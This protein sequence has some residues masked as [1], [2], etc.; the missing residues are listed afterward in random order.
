[1]IPWL[2]IAGLSLLLLLAWFWFDSFQSRAAA[3]AAAQAL[4]RAEDLLL[5]DE[6]VALAQLRLVR[7][8]EGRLR[9]QRTYDFEFSDTGDNRRAGR[10]TLIGA[11]LVTA[12]LSPEIFASGS[13]R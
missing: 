10:V 1:M 12:H 13:R 6:T 11:T 7:D 2:E 5:L 9:L 3:L 4:C 8:E